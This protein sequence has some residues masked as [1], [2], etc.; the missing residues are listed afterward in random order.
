MKLLTQLVVISLLSL[1]PA[2]I[3]HAQVPEVT[4]SVPQQELININSADEKMLAK[5][6]GIGMKKAKSIVQ[7]RLENG[8]FETV[9]ELTK[10]KGVGKKLVAKLEGKIML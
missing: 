9:D 5:L 10:V 4:Q 6:P 1:L 7:Y 2:S 3:L 8:Q